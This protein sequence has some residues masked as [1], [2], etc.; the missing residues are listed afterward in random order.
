MFKAGKNRD[1][2]FSND[3]ILETTLN[4]IEIFETHY[5]PESGVRALFLFDNAQTHCKRAENALSACKMPKSTKQWLPRS[6]VRMRDGTLPNGEKQPLWFPDDHPDP[7][8]AGMFKGMEVILRERGPW[9]AG[10]LRVQC[11]SFK[12]PTPNTK[13][14]CC[15]RRLLFS[16]SDF[17]NQKSK[18]QELV[19][20]WG[21]HF[22]YYPKFHCEL[23]FI[24]MCWGRAKF[25]YRMYGI[26]RDE[27]QQEEYVRKALDSV[28]PLTMIR[29]VLAV[30]HFQL[31]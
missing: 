8:K 12:C 20:G 5:P 4:A 26:P 11:E 29:C 22:L 24:E 21:H 13:T 27:D 18:L 15:A 16:Q 6:G 17:V 30:P 28:S 2:Y 9:P 10:G 23:N 31:Y 3:N 19:E 7:K 25:E 14:D 1:G